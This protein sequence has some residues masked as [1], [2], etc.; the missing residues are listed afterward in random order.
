MITRKIDFLDLLPPI[1]EMFPDIDDVPPADSSKY[2]YQITT[3]YGKYNT[4]YLEFHLFHSEN[5]DPSEENRMSNGYFPEAEYL[6]DV[7]FISKDGEDE[8]AFYDFS[9]DELGVTTRWYD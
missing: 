5:G 9:A 2:L 8:F 6:M 7:K 4:G 1:R 3:S